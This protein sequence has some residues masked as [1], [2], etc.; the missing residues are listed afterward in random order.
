MEAWGDGL[1]LPASGR[2]GATSTKGVPASQWSLD[3]TFL[4]LLWDL[5]SATSTKLL[6]VKMY[7]YLLSLL[8][9]RDDTPVG[10]VVNVSQTVFGL[11][12]A[13]NLIVL[14]FLRPNS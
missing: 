5:P 7:R 4:A 11:L 14:R 2:P 12:L 1:S 10:D 8:V 3:F 13:T 6:G 9:V